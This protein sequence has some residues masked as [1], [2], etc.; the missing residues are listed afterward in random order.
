MLQAGFSE[1]RC[2]RGVWGARCLIEIR[3]EGSG[4]RIE[5]REKSTWLVGID[6]HWGWNVLQTPTSVLRAGC[7]R[8]GVALE[9][10]ALGEEDLQQR[11]T[12][13][14]LMAAGCPLTAVPTGPSW[15]GDLGG[16]VLAED[17]RPGKL[18]LGVHAYSNRE[19]KLLVRLR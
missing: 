16:V 3:Q 17:L 19:S 4:G 7:S 11:L 9:E 5:Q 13:K 14:E 1:N 15:R 10:E 2:C 6:L 8:K 18:I 12:L